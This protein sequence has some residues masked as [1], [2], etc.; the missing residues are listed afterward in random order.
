[1]ENLYDENLNI[2]KA[3]TVSEENIFLSYVSS[4]NDGKSLRPSMLITRIK[5]IFP[6]L[7]EKNDILDNNEDSKKEII[8]EKQLYENLIN[9]ISNLNEKEFIKNK[10]NNILKYYYDRI[11]YK[12]KL[13]DNLNYINYSFLPDKIKLENIQKLYGKKIITS[14]SKLEKYRSCPFSYFLQYE[15]RLKKKK[16]SKFKV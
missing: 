2:Y 16:N 5:K 8:S 13:I 3:F 14:V 9:K 10:W 1:M 11:E 6:N 12:N 15:L 7:I 4:D